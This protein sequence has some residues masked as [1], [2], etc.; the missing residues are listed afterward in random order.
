MIASSQARAAMTT[1]TP[2]S[3]TRDRQAQDYSRGLAPFRHAHRNVFRS[4][5]AGLCS[6]KGPSRSSVTCAHPLPPG[7]RAAGSERDNEGLSSVLSDSTT[8]H[9]A[10]VQLA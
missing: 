2:H 6:C 1:S 4:C 5:Q 7:G 9:P 3:A 8:S 10:A